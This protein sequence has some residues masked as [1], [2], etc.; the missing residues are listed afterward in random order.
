[1]EIALAQQPEFTLSD[2]VTRVRDALKRRWKMMALISGIVFV[3]GTIAVFLITPQYQASARVRIDPSRDPVAAQQKTTVTLSDEA[4]DTEVSS[5]YGL[6]VAKAVV[7]KLNLANDPEFVETDKDDGVSTTASRE[8]TAATNLLK[9]LSVSRE[10]QTYVLNVGFE[11]VDPVKA[12]QIANAFAEAHIEG[13]V[14]TRTSVASGQAEWYQQQLTE[15]NGQVRAAEALAA[16]Y[17][18]ENGLSL[19]GSDTGSGTGTISDQQV[20]ALSANLA[21]AESSAAAARANYLAARMQASR[22]GPGSVVEVLQSPVISDLRAKRADIL[23]AKAEMESRYGKRY[24]DTQKIDA[25]L[26]NIDRQIAAESERII[27]SLG[28]VAKAADARAASLRSSLAGIEKLRASQTQAKVIA[29]SLTREADAKRDLYRQL[30]EESLAVQQTAQNSM[31]TATI[32]DR[33]IPPKAPH[34]PNKPLFISLALIVALMAGAGTIATQEM[35]AGTVLKASDI[36]EKLGLSLLTVVPKVAD[37]HPAHLL[38]DRPTSFFAEAFRIARGAILG[39]GETARDLKVIAFTSAI[40]GEGKTTTS[41]S[42]ARTLAVAGLRTLIVD[43]DLRRAAMQGAA[44]VGRTNNG[45]VE[46]LKGDAELDSVITASALENLDMVLV[47]EP[48]FTSTNLFESD[49]MQMLV[50]AARQRYD[51]VILDLPPLLGLADGRML[52]NYA[53][54]LVFVVKWNDTP[55]SVAQ[56]ALEALRKTAREPIGAIVNAVDENA[57]AL[58]GS[59]YQYRYAYYY[60]EANG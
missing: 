28:S 41:L 4:I 21:D 13:A 59:Y 44:E 20:P 11:S 42:F 49:R 56:S 3:L 8:D 40:P 55:L 36:E 12:A 52:A 30:S 29:D 60:Q 58:G 53:E 34:F 37:E 38:I 24:P 10:G 54:G 50:S 35:L 57:E 48:Y 25:Q 31:S 6:D 16:R 1:M 22:S 18:A 32:V 39:A 2:V 45:L 7:S 26:D 33:A 23:T 51:H 27:S 15:L 17:R 14:N 43:C 9:K 46:Y 19:G 47:R 5:F